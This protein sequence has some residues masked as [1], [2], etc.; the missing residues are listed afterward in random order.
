MTSASRRRTPRTLVRTALVASLALLPALA[1]AGQHRVDVSNNFFSDSTLTV[2]AGDQIGWVWTPG[3]GNHTVT[4]GTSGSSGGD[5][6]FSSGS[7]SGE[8]RAFAWKSPPGSTARIRYY[9]V[10]HFFMGMHGRI[11]FSAARVP[12]AEFRIG[13]VRF[14]TVHDSDYVEIVNLGDAAGNLGRY[15]LSVP[16]G[17]LLTLAPSS[18]PVPVNGRVV[19][20]LGRSGAGSATEQFFPGLSLPRT[21]SAALYLPTS[22]IADTVRTRADLMVDFV[23]WGA[24]AQLNEST[25]GTAA[26]WT[27]GTFADPPADGNTLEFCGAAADRGV[28]FWQGSPL[29]TPGTVNCVTP[30]RASSWGRIKAIYR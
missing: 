4:S 26:Y 20:W 28:A 1:G 7:F 27:A 3:S 22:K 19:V 13:E 25:A 12:V 6:T 9:C 8:G 11:D 14:S 5:G 21:G 30:A 17:T 24:A 16:S 23:Q 29:S 2:N 18:L 15:R 10:P